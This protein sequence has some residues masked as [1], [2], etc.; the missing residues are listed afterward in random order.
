MTFYS[1]NLTQNVTSAKE[2]SNICQLFLD[3]PHIEGYIREQYI[4]VLTELESYALMVFERNFGK[5]EM[6]EYDAGLVEG[7]HQSIE[8]VPPIISKKLKESKTRKFSQFGLGEKFG[9]VKKIFEILENSSQRQDEILEQVKFHYFLGREIVTELIT[10][11]AENDGKQKLEPREKISR[12]FVYDFFFKNFKHFRVSTND[13][14][15]ILDKFFNSLYKKQDLKEWSGNEGKTTGLQKLYPGETVKGKRVGKNGERVYGEFAEVGLVYGIIFYKN[16][17]VYAGH[18]EKM[19]RHGLGWMRKQNGSTCD[20]HWIHGKWVTG[21]HRFSSGSEIADFRNNNR[22]AVWIYKQSDFQAPKLQKARDKLAR[23]VISGVQ[24]GLYEG[25]FKGEKRDGQGIMYFSDCRIY[26]GGWVKG[27]KEGSGRMLT[28]KGEDYQGEWKANLRHGWGSMKFENGDFYR[29]Q[30]ENG[31]MQ[32]RGIMER[33]N[34]DLEDGQWNENDF[35]AKERNDKFKKMKTK[36]S[37][38][39]KS[40]RNSK[41]NYKKKVAVD[42]KLIKKRT[43]KN[44]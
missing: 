1:Q 11:L 33:A 39:N 20:G 34:G 2:C 32:G 6:F 3:S 37:Q 22:K 27:V 44:K 9:L 40:K 31:L 4:Q 8:D 43:I 35:V 21:V 41:L 25:G 5:V 12:D 10:H 7:I 16:G 15:F 30:W 42:K 28:P 19:I 26:I 36:K 29:G 13:A 24:S 23:A 14:M 17:E 18:V 38:M